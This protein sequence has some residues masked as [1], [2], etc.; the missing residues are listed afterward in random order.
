[1]LLNFRILVTIHPIGFK[2]LKG[3]LMAQKTRFTENSENN[4][5]KR[6]ISSLFSGNGGLGGDVISFW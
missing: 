6:L 2:L 3:F 4:R 1:M 5:K